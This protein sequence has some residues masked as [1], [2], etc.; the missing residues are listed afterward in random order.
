MAPAPDSAVRCA[1]ALSSSSS[2]TTHPR[3][4]SGAAKYPSAVTRLNITIRRMGLLRSR[5]QLHHRTDFHRTGAGK[6]RARHRQLHGLAE[7]ARLD[8]D[9]A[10]DQVFGF[11]VGA[12]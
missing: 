2:G 10:E 6:H 12:V 9:E 3:F 8:D 5:W 11:G 7:V 1:A 4:P